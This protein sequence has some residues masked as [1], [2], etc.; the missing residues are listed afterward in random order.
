MKISKCEST[1]EEVELL[2][3]II[4]ADGTAVNLDKIEAIHTAL[5]LEIS[6]KLRS[7]L[8]PAGYYRGFIQVYRYL[9]GLL[10]CYI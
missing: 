1:K 8:A 3:H 6:T 2:G 4:S 9:S 10:L 5:I 7:F